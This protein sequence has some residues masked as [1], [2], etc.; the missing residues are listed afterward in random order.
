LLKIDGSF[1]E[2]GGQI[3]RSAI[4]LSVLL[5]KPVEI[6]N[7]RSKRPNPGLRPQHIHSVK[8]LIKIFNAKVENLSIGNK[9]IKFIPNTHDNDLD[10]SDIDIDIGTAGSIS[11]ILQTIIPSVSLSKKKM[12]IKIIGGTDVMA[13]PTIDYMKYVFSE[14]YKS[15]GIDFTIDI[16]RRGYYPKGGGIVY[17]KISPCNNLGLINL[18]K[19]RTGEPRIVG[20]CSRLPRNVL[21][22]QVSTALLY[23]EKNGYRCNHYNASV[24]N[25]LSPGS[26]LLVYTKSDIGQ[27]VGGDAVGQKNKTAEEV[28]K[29]AVSKFLSNYNK[30]VPIDHYLADMIVPYMA[31]AEGAS[32]LLARTVS[33]HLETNIWLAE[34]MLKV[35][36]NIQR[37]NDLFLIEKRS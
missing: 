27:Y 8:A 36:F 6:F 1:G 34:K 23:L 21:D 31:L 15:I 14:M 20:V 12:K 29:E 2:G 26:S 35:K 11:M 30:K 10:I 22:R 32:S 3:L 5:K 7:I 33:E 9:S 4:S 13:S 18:T 25:A 16:V 28:G 37:M 24:E 19:P 17:V